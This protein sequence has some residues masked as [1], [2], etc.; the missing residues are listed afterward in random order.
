MII[1]PITTDLNKPLR[2]NMQGKPSQEL[3]SIEGNRLFDGP[4]AVIFGDE[5]NLTIEGRTKLMN[6]I[7]VFTQMADL[8]PLAPK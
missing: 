6:R 5:S 1:N 7:K 4:V 8:F 3:N 2:K